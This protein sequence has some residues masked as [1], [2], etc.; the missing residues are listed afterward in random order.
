M[1]WAILR[2]G[3]GSLLLVLRGRWVSGLEGEDAEMVFILQAGYSQLDSSTI[4]VSGTL[5]FR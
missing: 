4:E 5:P 1:C 2:L 3:D